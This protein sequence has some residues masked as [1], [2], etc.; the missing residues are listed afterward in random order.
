MKFKKEFLQD[1]VFGDHDE[2]V[3][4][5]SDKIDGT[6]RWSTLHTLIFKFEGK[7]YESDYSTGSTEYQDESPYEYDGD[8]I[9][10]CE[11]IPVEKVVTV[12]VK[13]K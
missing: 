6:S 4:V 13:A 1:I 5:I 7:Y 9:E 3:E 2:T 12:Y 11:V 10:C 8:E